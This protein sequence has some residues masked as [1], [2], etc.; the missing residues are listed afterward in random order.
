M[1][2]SGTAFFCK[3]L[4]HYGLLL[5]VKRIWYGGQQNTKKFVS[6]FG[7]ISLAT[8]GLRPQYTKIKA[9]KI[10][11]CKNLNLNGCYMYSRVKHYLSLVCLNWNLGARHLPEV[12]WKGCLG[13]VG[14]GRDVASSIASS[15]SHNSVF[16]IMG[17]AAKLCGQIRLRLLY[18]LF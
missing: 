8:V 17:S 2:C 18:Y 7:V 10:Y 9:N 14:R 6:Q 4:S 16:C 13:R 5:F 1:A 3:Y 15:S 12:C 11:G